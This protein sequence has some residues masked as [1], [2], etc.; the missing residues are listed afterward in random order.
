MNM[1]F[2]LI[3]LLLS[4]ELELEAPKFGRQVIL[5]DLDGDCD[6]D[7]IIGSR[8]PDGGKVYENLGEEN[9]IDVTDVTGIDFNSPTQKLIVSDINGDGLEDVFVY[10]PS[11]GSIPVAYRNLGDFYFEKIDAFPTTFTV[12]FLKF[13][14]IDGDGL[15]DAI[16]IRN[17]DKGS[18]LYLLKQAKTFEFEIV[19]SFEFGLRLRAILILDLNGDHLADIVPIGSFVKRVLLNMGGGFFTLK[20]NHLFANLDIK[21]AL[22][23]YISGRKFILLLTTGGIVLYDDSTGLF[24][25]C[26]S[27]IS[28]VKDVVASD[29]DF[30]GNM[31]VLLLRE[32]HSPLLCLM[33]EGGIKKSISIEIG[34]NIF[35]AGIGDIDG[36]SRYD[37]VLSG[38]SKPHIIIAGDTVKEGRRIKIEGAHLFNGSFHLFSGD[39]VITYPLNTSLIPSILYDSLIV[40]W[41]NGEE[42]T[43][44]PSREGTIEL[45][46]GKGRVKKYNFTPSTMDTILVLYPNPAEDI[47]N[48][49]YRV[50]ESAPVEVRILNYSGQTISL[51]ETSVKEPGR[52]LLEWEPDR[53]G[54]YIVRVK[55]KDRI[56]TK[57]V[58]VL[59]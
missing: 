15:S 21:K 42:E 57:K 5:K 39:M 14:D 44:I 23:I 1:Q 6:P 16:A 26:F 47:L 37:I 17:S 20:E 41:P 11:F 31:D 54:T 2:V 48:I 28:D 33:E 8:I 30:D 45:I 27:E 51:L 43:F 52:Y 36:D 19:D 32:L 4:G 18:V 49:S 24:I 59:K 55:I 53:P 10:E 50:T 22:P 7:I 25:N 34:D 35:G 12:N 46:K 3:F 40:E 58:V 13:F 9:F 56:F 29:V 38:D